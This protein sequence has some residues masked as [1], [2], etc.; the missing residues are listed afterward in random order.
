MKFENKEQVYYFLVIKELNF[1]RFK[2]TCELL[3][4]FLTPEPTFQNYLWDDGTIPLFEQTILSL[5]D[6]TLI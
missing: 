1:I 4:C 5:L 2:K 6:K 3:G